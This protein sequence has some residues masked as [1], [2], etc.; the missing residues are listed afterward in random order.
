VREENADTG[1]HRAIVIIKPARVLCAAGMLIMAVRIK[2]EAKVT[3]AEGGAILGRVDAGNSALIQWL[4]RA[5]EYIEEMGLD[6]ITLGYG[7]RIHAL[8][9]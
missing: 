7:L 3:M 6:G 5:L 9:R 8:S 2:Q 4:Q 1:D